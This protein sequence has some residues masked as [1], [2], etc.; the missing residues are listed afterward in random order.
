MRPEIDGTDQY[1]SFP[2]LLR[3]PAGEGQALLYCPWTRSARVLST[4]GQRLLQGCATF[5]TLDDHAVRL[6]RELNLLPFQVESVRREL[7]DLASAGLLV[8]RRRLWDAAR[9]TG[10]SDPPPPRIAAVGIPTRD[11]PRSL[12]ACLLGHVEAA[13]RQGRCTD[14]IVVD[15]S[16]TARGENRRLLDALA[17]RCGVAIWYG[18]PEDKLRFAAALARQAEA[19]PELVRF[20]LGIEEDW[21]I[22]TGG[23]RNALLLHT[24]GDLLLQ[25][26]DDTLCQALP[27][28]ECRE[29]L[30]LSA[31]F[32]PTEFWFCSEGQ[33]CPVPGEA[34]ETDL[35]GLHE[36]LLGRT[37]ADCLADSRVPELASAN[38]RFVR[39]LESG[40]GPILTTAAGVAG[41]SGMGSCLPLLTLEGASRARLHRSEAD[42]RDALRR[43]QWMRAVTRPTV[44]DGGYC[45]A[46][47]LGLDNRRLLPPFLPF[48]RNQ[49]GVFGAV[50][51]L[52]CGGHTGFLPWMVLH[53]SLEERSASN[54]EVP[55]HWAMQPQTGH[56]MQV[57]LGSFPQGS[58]TATPESRL[59]RLGSWLEEIAS[60]DSADFAEYIRLHV[61]NAQTRTA[62][63]LEA[64]L[65][66]YG[67]RP[68]YW[69]E[70]THRALTAL[71]ESLTA[72]EAGL[73]ADVCATWGP[74]QAQQ[75]FQ[76]L[77][78]RYGGL[79]RAWPDLVAAAKALRARGIH[80]P[81]RCGTGQGIGPAGRP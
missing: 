2:D 30:A 49:D 1:R 39:R 45:M 61:W 47:N 42:Y 11:R 16:V 71:T 69:A 22:T 80:L 60:W 63:Q 78:L 67:S 5:A 32:D 9:Q 55:W 54:P 50:L 34:S 68:T 3:F 74:D 35:L 29:E 24:V 59:A 64:Q 6:C 18:G 79:L 58:G 14:F 20:A 23:S 36:Q 48:Q 37:V 66:K 81:T 70:D 4:I 12:R 51:A 41:D 15:E 52:C 7:A 65:R 13:Q 38:A 21:P 28:P 44:T 75:R 19:P 46:L 17:D 73:P 76:R 53:H 57:L 27:A 31:T 10:R 33:P 8:S 56:L 62:S 43:R 25:V 72:P 26:D 40:A 77:V